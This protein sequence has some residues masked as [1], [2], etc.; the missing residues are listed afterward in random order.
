MLMPK[1]ELLAP[2]GNREALNAA[3]AHGAD[4]VYFA[5]KKFGA[6]AYLD[7]FSDDEVIDMIEEAHRFDVKAYITVN[8]I[9]KDIEM[10]EAKGWVD[11]LVSNHADAII[12]QDWG[13]LH[14]ILEAY[15]G[16]PVHASTQM[17]THSLAQAQILYELGVKRIIFARETSLEVIREVIQKVPIETEVFVHGALCMSHSGNC[18]MS[19]LLGKRSGNRGRCAQ[20]CRLPYQLEGVSDKAYLLSPKDLMTLD[21]LDTI[22][23]S[24][25]T[26]L[27]IEGRM[28]RSEYVGVITQAYRKAIDHVLEGVTSNQTKKN[29]SLMF[30]R[31]FTKGF[32]LR[33]ANHQFTNTTSPNHIG[34]QIGVAKRYINGMIEVEL[35]EPIAQNDGLRIGGDNEDAIVVNEIIVRDQKL[36]KATP[37]MMVRLRVHKEIKCPAPVLKTTDA[38][39]I[40]AI[41]AT[42]KPKISL[43]GK[44][45]VEANHLVFEVSDGHHKIIEKSS[46]EVEPSSNPTMKDRIIEQLQKTGAEDYTFTQITADMESV[47]LPIKDIN[48]LRRQ[49]LYAIDEARLARKTWVKHSITSPSLIIE[50]SANLVVKVHTLHQLEQCLELGLS[51][52]LVEKEAWLTYANEVTH[53]HY[54]APRIT[55]LRHQTQAKSGVTEIVSVYDNVANA[56]SV[57]FKHQQGSF[58]V[59][60]SVELSQQEIAT[61]LSTYRNKYHHEPNVMVMVYGYHQL[62]ITKHCLIN[63]ALGFQEKYCGACHREQ[64]YLKDRLGFRLPLMD[65]GDCNLIVLNSKRLHLMQMI[66]ALK[67][68]GVHNFLIEFTIEEDIRDIARAYQAAFNGSVQALEL[69][70]V[71][72]GYIKEGVI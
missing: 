24:N 53:V 16:Y 56:E 26:S 45:L 35:T 27:K 14:Y 28:K 9:I 17:N 64:Y 2:V 42:P 21:D 18:F 41:N 46:R 33:E 49:A 52:V 62:M 23:N 34:I 55:P 13:L 72:Y 20:P 22:I 69:T 68:N 15:P 3:I 36:T 57:Y 48:E 12:V 40:E 39:L 5:G 31:G 63:K 60:L 37:P 61:L 7:Q 54:I 71:T 29:M 38:T 11:F 25:V 32:I 1:V 50:P 58:L 47:F 44:I 70:D 43:V 67:N 4:A 30:N 8:T 59:G 66:T 6:R 10:G 19:S 65:D 51:H